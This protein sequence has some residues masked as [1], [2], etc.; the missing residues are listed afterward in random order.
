N[1]WQFAGGFKDAFS[2]YYKFGARYYDPVIGRWT[3]PDPSG[4]DANSYAYAGSNPANFVDPSGLA[5]DPFPSRIKL[6][7]EGTVAATIFSGANG[8][9]RIFRGS[10]QAFFAPATGPLTPALVFRGVTNIA[11]GAAALNK[12]VGALSRADKWKSGC[13]FR[14]NAVSFFRQV[15]PFGDSGRLD[16]LGGAA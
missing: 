7:K 6:C 15:L 5:S 14:E 12:A 8:I 4:M 3:Q 9:F 11:R 1:P 16:F 2:G 13:S 10:A